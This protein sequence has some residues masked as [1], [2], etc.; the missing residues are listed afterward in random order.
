MKIL[1]IDENEP[2]LKQLTNSIT[3]ALPGAQIFAF[4][5]PVELLEFA[6]DNPCDIAFLE[7][8]MP[9]MSGITMAKKL[10]SYNP[11]INIIFVSAYCENTADA[12]ALHP[13]GFVI[14]PVTKEAIEREIKHLRHLLTPAVTRP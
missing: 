3:E 12:F 6:Q 1:V 14:K 2:D 10:Q 7:M 13:S 4:S 5:N 9:V 11:K 8:V